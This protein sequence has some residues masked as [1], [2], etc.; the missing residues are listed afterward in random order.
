MRSEQVEKQ[1][2]DFFGWIVLY[3]LGSLCSKVLQPVGRREERRSKCCYFGIWYAENI[4][5]YW[6]Y[7]F[8]SFQMDPN[9]YFDYYI[10]A[11]LLVLQLEK[12]EN[13]WRL[14][15][16]QNNRPSLSFLK[17][18]PETDWAWRTSM[19][20]LYSQFRYCKYVSSNKI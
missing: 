7:N 5:A 9:P 8:V 4:T 3:F 1:N 10:V 18:L 16:K 11:R 17:V 19:L 13:G 20:P 2:C 15:I 12:L 14:L 6:T